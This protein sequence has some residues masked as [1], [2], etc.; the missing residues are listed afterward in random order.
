MITAPDIKLLESERMTD[1]TDG[2]GRRTSRVVPD[3]VAGN[4]F[5]KVSRLDSVYGR[6]N[7]RK[8][9]GAV[10]TDS[11]DVYAGA[12]AIITDAPDNERIHVTL[13]STSS[14]FDTRTEARDRIESYV[15]SGPESRMVL[16]GRQLAGQQA[17]LCYQREEEALPEIGEVFCLSKESGTTVL[18]QQYF[19]VQSIDHEVRTFTDLVGST[20]SEFTRRVL[21]IGTGIAL[22]YEFSGPETPSRYS[23]GRATRRSATP[24]WW[25][26]RATSA[27]R[28][29]PRRPPLSRWKSGGEVYT[30]IVPTTNRETPVS[31][32]TITARSTPSPPSLDRQRSD[33]DDVERHRATAIT[34]RAIKPAR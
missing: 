13:F 6:V 26:R 3:G 22:R 28:S 8:V 7:L 32:A 30:P 20:A 15:A 33:H 27:S 25:M 14:D 23:N 19:R 4:I 34:R 2:G 21:S 16:F 18:A 17:I 12:H 29:C 10:Q 1:T 9:Y 31:S 5:P 24:P 11:L